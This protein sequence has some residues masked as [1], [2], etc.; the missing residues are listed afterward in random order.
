MSSHTHML[1]HL[2]QPRE[3]VTCHFHQPRPQR[4][5]HGLGVPEPCRRG[6]DG[7]QRDQFAGS[8]PGLHLACLPS[9]GA[10]PG[11]LEH[12]REDG[13]QAPW[14]PALPLA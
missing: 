3:Q 2:E 6:K 9:L 7:P 5:R 8:P 1:G 4:A 14:E 13:S 12:W 10:S 11:M